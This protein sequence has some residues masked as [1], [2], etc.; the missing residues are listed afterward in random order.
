MPA[1]IC[2]ACN[3]SSDLRSNFCRHL[4]TPK[5]KKRI[6]DSYTLRDEEEKK[7]YSALL[8]AHKCSQN[9]ENDPKSAHKSLCSPK[10]RIKKKGGDS[11]YICEFCEK[12][13]SRSSNL[14]RHHELYCK[15]IN[16]KKEDDNIKN[17]LE[18]TI[19]QQSRDI[20]KILEK[21]PSL[22]EISNIRSKSNQNITNNHIF[23]NTINNFSN[24][25]NN[26]ININNFGNENLDMLTNKFMSAMIDKPYTAIPKMI[27]KIHFNDKY[28]ENKNIRMVNKKDNKLQIIEN[29]KWIYVD[30][31]E[32]LDM[33]LG[34][35]NY[36][37][38]DY[39]EKNKSKFTEAQ[40]HRFNNFQEKIGESDKQVNQNI[41][42]D[43]DLVFWNNM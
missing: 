2:K 40:I 18:K 26:T 28:P 8:I 29:G 24:T 27:K 20:H 9:A 15:K 31:D 16:K 3:F 39:Y 30:K 14:K 38:D 32:T 43:T 6:V 7:E 22:E 35:K 11:L 5:H 33:L 42:K 21:V 1:Y 4:L 34:D 10:K 13:F 12:T 41:V 17:I 25:I 37:L 19:I 23:H 36:Q